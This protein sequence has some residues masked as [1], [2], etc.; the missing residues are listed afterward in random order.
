MTRSLT[1]KY[2]SEFLEAYGRAM[3]S[4]QAVEFRLLL[5]FLSVIR[6][7]DQHIASAVY[8][9]VT[10]VN[11]RLEMI[12]EG[13]KVA[14]SEAALQQQEWMK[15][16]KKIG[17]H[18]AKRNFLAHYTVNMHHA[19]NGSVTLHLTRS[20]FD[21][22]DKERPEVDLRQLEEYERLFRQLA[23]TIDAFNQKSSASLAH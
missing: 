18:T 22:R 15:L 9:A 10:N 16:R 11:T 5:L 20:I 7:R 1:D 6:A 17:E 4:W 8:H 3:L 14:L 13:L 2:T 23:A 12:T 21:T 19:Q